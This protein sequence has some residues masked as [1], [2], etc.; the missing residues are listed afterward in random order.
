VLAMTPSR[1]DMWDERRVDRVAMEKAPTEGRCPDVAEDGWRVCRVPGDLVGVGLARPATAWCRMKQSCRS[2][3]CSG[4]TGI[5]TGACWLRP[6][7]TG[8][9]SET[10]RAATSRSDGRSTSLS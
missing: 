1:H 4:P 9:R 8:F 5:R 6:E 2:M 3:T 7:M 10:A